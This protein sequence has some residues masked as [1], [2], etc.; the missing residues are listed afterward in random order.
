MVN[1]RLAGPPEGAAPSAPSPDAATTER[2]PPAG[3]DVRCWPKRNR[4]SV[5][6]ELLLALTVIGTA[7]LPIAYS[8]HADQRLCRRYYHHAVAMEIVD[9][10]LEALVAGDWRAFGDGTHPYP[11]RA[12]AARNLPAGAFTLTVQGNRL[13]LE[14]R[15]T[16]RG[17]AT[18]ISREARGQ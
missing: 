11:V 18:P 13:R 15:P 4:G 9:G 8:V 17:Q 1:A 12:A 6:I 16:A 10:E 2:R 5:M 14:W 3:R 7:L